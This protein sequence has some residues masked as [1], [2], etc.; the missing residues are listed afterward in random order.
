MSWRFEELK[1]FARKS[2]AT[3]MMAAPH[4]AQTFQRLPWWVVKLFGAGFVIASARKDVVEIFCLFFKN[5]S[6]GPGMW[7]SFMRIFGRS[8]FSKNQW[9]CVA[10]YSMTPTWLHMDCSMNL[11]ECLI[12]LEID[13]VRILKLAVSEA[14]KKKV[15]VSDVA[16][17]VNNLE[18]QKKRNH[19]CVITILLHA[20]RP[21]E[22]LSSGLLLLGWCCLR[23]FDGCWWVLLR[24]VWEMFERRSG[25]VER[26]LRD[27]WEMFLNDSVRCLRIVGV[28][29]LECCWGCW[30]LLRDV[31][32][33]ST[34]SQHSLKL[35]S[36]SHCL[37]SLPTT[38]FKHSLNTPAPSAISQQSLNSLSTN[39]VS[40]SYLSTVSPNSLSLSLNL[41][42]TF[43]KQTHSLLDSLFIPAEFPQATPSTCFLNTISI[44]YFRKTGQYMHESLLT[45]M[46]LPVKNYLKIEVG[47]QH[48][49]TEH[50]LLRHLAQSAEI[51]KN[52]IIIHHDDEIGH[53]KLST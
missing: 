11:E 42:S 38:V 12:L 41:L 34:V 47:L 19:Y 25:D 3:F 29:S 37:N 51:F 48:S 2:K 7:L 22:A 36:H 53:Q 45:T 1:R 26:C 27:V 10:P 28:M 8:I 24:D 35:L 50:F 9:K 6:R 40:C 20:F 49:V 14:A 46:E 52:R 13:P 15:F 33:L 30:R 5:L 16:W 17:V 23:L 43:Q 4:S 18:A 32:V 31:L 44:R 39:I 21:V